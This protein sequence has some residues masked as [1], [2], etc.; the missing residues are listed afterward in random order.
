MSTGATIAGKYQLLRPLGKG[1]MGEVWAARHVGLGREV[2]LKLIYE[3]SPEL[4]ARLKREA[5]ACGRL[6]HPNV[7][8]VYDF[9][10]TESGDPFL[11]MELLS[12]ETLADRLASS[13]RL[14]AKEAVRIMLD[15]ARA[16]SAAHAAGVVHRDLKPANVFLCQS[17][18]GESVKVLDFGVSKIISVDDMSV[19]TT[20]ALV[21]SPAYMSPEQ[22][23]A[24]REI[25]PRADL[26]SVGVLLFEMLTGTRPFPSPTVVGV[27]ADILAG[28]IPTLASA[29]AD[30]DP[31]LDAAVRRCLTRDLDKRMP[32]AAALIEALT[33]VL[34][35]LDAPAPPSERTTAP[36]V[37]MQLGYVI[38]KGSAED[39]PLD[40]N[41]P[42][43][44]ST[45]A[46]PRSREPEPSDD[47][48][49]KETNVLT[50]S[51]GVAM[52]AVARA[53]LANRAPQA[54]SRT[55]PQVQLVAP[56]TP[57]PAV[58]AKPSSAPPPPPPPRA[59]APSN[60]GDDMPT[61]VKPGAV[62]EQVV[63]TRIVPNPFAAHASPAN[64]APQPAQALTT[65]MPWDAGPRPVAP[66]PAAP[67]AGAMQTWPTQPPDH[68]DA[69]RITLPPGWNSAQSDARRLL[70]ITAIAG[71]VVG[72]VV[73]AALSLLR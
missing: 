31:R 55:I 19:T 60:D 15:V 54:P 25:D 23:R 16:L 17:P 57:P 5:L 10:E 58:S 24:L 51:A 69:S 3:G 1:S 34:A 37:Q 53:A 32:S 4:A 27:V 62:V 22:A 68:T 43:E 29:L 30:V 63:P 45:I 38:K 8:R 18:H 40:P 50:G 6:E 52:R 21:G 65:P 20:G 64:R 70:W 41:D 72:L 67:P 48:D 2:A 66:P 46:L 13:P 33:P 61:M 35:D 71:I 47:D 59:P 28:P 12:G 7:V 9:G 49:E 26:W 44:A 11:V 39:V 36:R 14:D 56:P 73:F 42:D